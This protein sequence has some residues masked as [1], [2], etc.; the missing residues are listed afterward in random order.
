M[1]TKELHG[2]VSDELS[3]VPF[4]IELCAP[5][6]A[7]MAYG[8]G[9]IY[10]AND[11]NY[12]ITNGHNVTRQNSETK[13]RISESMAFPVKMRLSLK[14]SI[15]ENKLDTRLFEI[16]LYSD[17]EYR[18]PN[19]FIHPNEG[20]HIDVI[21]L[22]ILEIPEKVRI[23]PINK[24]DFPPDLAIEVSDEVFILGFPFNIHGGKLLPIWKRGSIAS[25]PG[26]NYNNL[27][28]FLVDAA[29]RSGM[30]GSPVVLKRRGKE[31][32]LENGVPFPCEGTFRNFIGV[33]S[34]RIGSGKD[35]NMSKIQLGIVWRKSVIK[36]IISGGRV[37]DIGFQNI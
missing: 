19:W 4:R 9:F 22:P 3:L 27:P 8:T 23:F 35:P 28:C 16:E 25:E 5:T 10:Q 29:S 33:Y 6:G 7:I 32:I 1:D 20:Y 31:M 11:K 26:I 2:F 15:D 24:V 36:E 21:A 34:G 37:S 17:L 18:I 14:I 12:I 30:S 13:E